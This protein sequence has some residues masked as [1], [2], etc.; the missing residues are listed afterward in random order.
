M[1]AKIIGFAPLALLVGCAP[2]EISLNARQQDVRA[3]LA[4][5]VTAGASLPRETRVIDVHTHTFNGR[6]LPFAGILLGKRDVHPAAALLSD[7]CARMLAQA[8]IDRTQLAHAGPGRP[9][10]SRPAGRQ[11]LEERGG[12]I[13]RVLIGLINKAEQRGVWDK[14]VPPEEQRARVMQ[15][16]NDMNLGERIAVQATMEMMGMEE[17][18][19]EPAPLV[20]AAMSGGSARTKVSGLQAAVRFIW[21]IT[22]SDERQ[23]DF[24]RRDFSRVPMKG[25]PLMVSHMMDLGP[26]YDQAAV[27]QTLLAFRSGQI[28][29]ME[30]LQNRGGAGMIYFVAYVPYR[31]HFDGGREGDAL[32]LVQEAVRQRG[33]WGVKFYP[34][35][36]FRPSGNDIPRRPFS[37]NR[38]AG[39]QWQARYGPLGR[40]GAAKLD[41]QAEELFAWCE[42]EQVPIFVHCSTGEFEARKG[43]GVSNSNPKYWE[44]VLER[45]PALRLCLGHAG[46]G[47]LWFGG[48]EY[49]GWG[50]KVIELCRKYPNVYCELTTHAELLNAN[51]QAFFADLLINEFATDET[52]P[53]GRFPL[54]KKLMYGTDWYLPDASERADVLRA[55][56]RVF[57]HPKLQGVFGDYFSGNAARYLNIKQRLAG[58]QSLAVR[59]RLQPFAER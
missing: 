59:E 16:A 21:Q 4:G 37:L 11:L 52:L 36:G 19:K 47:D 40:N 56:Q 17:H 43:Y 22:Q 24:F 32:K 44:A 55:T 18:T 25:A 12:P 57:Q 48:G 34:P 38:F 1:L 2:R 26:V 49:A 51:R 15:V 6:Y 7:D 13:C 50:T 45:H 9:G 3:S 58:V 53:A 28:R 46:S 14:S 8:L 54:R 20:T 29:R 23:P 30:A 27:G 31:D 35:S 39:R 42:R 33:A 41:A 10:I 5:R